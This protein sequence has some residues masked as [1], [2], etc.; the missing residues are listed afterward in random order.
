MQLWPVTDW[1]HY[2]SYVI[3]SVDVTQTHIFCETYR[4]VQWVV[5]NDQW[6]NFEQTRT[7]QIMN[8]WLTKDKEWRMIDD[9]KKQWQ[10]WRVEWI[11]KNYEQS[12]SKWQTSMKSWMNC[13]EWCD[14]IMNGWWEINDKQSNE[15]T[16]DKQW[17]YRVGWMMRKYEQHTNE[18]SIMN[19]VRWI[20]IHEYV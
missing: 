19:G 16:N 17:S 2:L 18:W 10:E 15:W 1:M 3:H 11:M 8:K 5:M 6:I 14:M 12:L 7:E 4:F 13:Y 9:R 20:W